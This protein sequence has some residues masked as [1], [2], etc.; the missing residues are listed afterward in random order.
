M[1]EM[2]GGL[3]QQSDPAT[4]FNLLLPHDQI[5]TGMAQGV[6]PLMLWSLQA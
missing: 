1:E 5:H 6:F 2:D 3:L 4:L